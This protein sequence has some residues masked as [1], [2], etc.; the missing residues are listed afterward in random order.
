M[1]YHPWQNY[2][3]LSLFIYLRRSHEFVFMEQHM[4]GSHSLFPSCVSW[5]SNSSCQPSDRA[6]RWPSWN[7]TQ[8]APVDLLNGD[9][10]YWCLLCQ[11]ALCLHSVTRAHRKQFS[12]LTRSLEG[13]SLANVVDEVLI[14]LILLIYN[15]S[16]SE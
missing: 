6:I 13:K 11:S 2:Y 1:H 16:L 14:V 15:I 9:P 3:F 5:D 12:L 8:T 10:W 7:S 4:F